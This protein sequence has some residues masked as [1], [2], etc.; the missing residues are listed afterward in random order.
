MRDSDAEAVVDE[1]EAIVQRH[2]DAGTEPTEDLAGFYESIARQAIDSEIDDFAMRMLPMRRQ[3]AMLEAHVEARWGE[4]LDLLDLLRR[5]CWEAGAETAEH[6]GQ[7]AAESEDYRFEALMRLQGRATLTLSEIIALLRSGH[8]TGAMGR[9]RTLHE[10]DVTVAFLSEQEDAI[11]YRFLRY[12]DAQTL[13]LRRAF[14]RYHEQ[15]GYEPSD[16]VVDG[17][18]RS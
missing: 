17:D 14:D 8:S 18:P 4:A 9:W 7:M 15:L 11:A 13:K 5:L 10:V 16:P 12:E 1:V 2:L 6:Y 3:M